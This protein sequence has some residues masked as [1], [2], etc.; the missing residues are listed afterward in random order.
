M[1]TLSLITL[2][3]FVATAG[4]V[5]GKPTDAPADTLV[6]QA[7]KMEEAH[8]AWLAEKPRKVSIQFLKAE[9]LPDALAKLGF[10]SAAIES[11]L[12]ILISS[13]DDAD[14]IEGVAVSTDGSDPT[15]VLKE[16]GWRVSDSGDP[17]IKI[18]KRT[19]GQQ[20]GGGESAVAPRSKPAE[21]PFLTRAELVAGKTTH[22]NETKVNQLDSF[23]ET[24]Q[25]QVKLTEQPITVRL[26]EGWGMWPGNFPILLQMHD[27][28]GNHLMTHDIT[29]NS[30][31]PKGAWLFR[32]G[33][34]LF[35]NIECEHRFEREEGIYAFKLS[36]DAHPCPG[37]PVVSKAA[38]QMA[39]RLIEDHHAAQNQKTQQ[40]GGGE[41]ATRSKS[42]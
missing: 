40:D 6:A 13:Q 39:G 30:A 34:D 8:K 10:K 15:R 7:R 26:W 2:A 38:L 16:S 35:L 41:S 14:P 23:Q 36:P 11:G 24:H 32:Q 18:L 4:L 31:A 42:K 9:K 12:V 33:W 1:N 29:I 25:W 19:K 21:N 28:S 20:E 37:G 22:Q 17:R 5:M 3:V 27:A